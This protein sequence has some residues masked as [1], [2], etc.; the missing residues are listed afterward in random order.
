[1]S[2][3][4][5]FTEQLAFSKNCGPSLEVVDRICQ[6]QL[7]GF[8][9]AS[10]GNEVEDRAGIDFVLAMESGSSLFLDLK[11]RDKDF[12]KDD[13]ALEIWSVVPLRDDCADGRPGWTWDKKKKTDYVLFYWRDT[14][15]F[16]LVPFHP[17][18]RVF[19][20]NFRNWIAASFKT[21]RQT[22]TENG[23]TWQSECIFIP[24]EL[25]VRGI[26]KWFG[27]AICEL[28][29]HGIS[30]PALDEDWLRPPTTE[31]P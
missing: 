26:T 28:A 18:H 8:L 3:E 6:A 29:K 14:C 10:H 15:R 21:A 12:G 25:V 19:R 1:M 4:F 5:T 11:L 20:A 24:R 13:V 27:G 9:S 31:T 7:P 23:G 17:L 2:R 16:F 22:T 30:Q